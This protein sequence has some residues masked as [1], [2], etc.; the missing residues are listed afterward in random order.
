M[1]TVNPFSALRKD[2]EKKVKQ[3]ACHHI[4]MIFFFSVFHNKSLD[5]IED[6]S[7]KERWEIW[8]K[9]DKH[10]KLESKAG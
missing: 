3:A 8:K 10:R 1:H 6:R 9:G 4:G 5:K 7:E 2:N